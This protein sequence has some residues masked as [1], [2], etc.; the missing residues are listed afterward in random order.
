VVPAEAAE[1]YAAGEVL[2]AAIKATSTID[3]NAIITWLHG[4]HVQSV[5]GSFGWDADGR[6]TGGSTTLVQW[7]S[8]HLN[9]VY[10]PALANRGV[11]PTYPKPNW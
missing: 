9:I 11:T 6:P 2:A 8:H 3:N 4:H 1:A 5:E 7:Q 10:P